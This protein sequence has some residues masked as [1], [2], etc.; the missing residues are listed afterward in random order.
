MA[1]RTLLERWGSPD[2]VAHAVL[3]L[4]EADYITGEVIIVDG[5]ERFGHRKPKKAR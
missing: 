3:F 2:D 5:G 4:I 1:R